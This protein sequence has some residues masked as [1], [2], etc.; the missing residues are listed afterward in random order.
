METRI[1]GNHRVE[2]KQ[3]SQRGQT[4]TTSYKKVYDVNDPS[5]EVLSVTV[6]VFKKKEPGWPIHIVETVGIRYKIHAWD[7]GYGSDMYFNWIEIES[8]KQIDKN[9][10]FVNKNSKWVKNVPPKQMKEY[11]IVHLQ[12]PRPAKARKHSMRL[13]TIILHEL[14]G[15]REVP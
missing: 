2:N 5:G 13:T 14:A 11:Q 10:Y 7:I 9:T 1:L 12:V 3:T 8:Q 4:K 15:L 6:S